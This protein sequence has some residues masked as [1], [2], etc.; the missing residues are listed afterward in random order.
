MSWWT[1]YEFLYIIHG[2]TI[3]VMIVRK[4][5]NH[6]EPVHI[7]ALSPLVDLIF[8]FSNYFIYEL[9]SLVWLGPVLYKTSMFFDNYLWY[10]FCLDVIVGDL[11]GFIFVRWALYYH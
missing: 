8:I 7:L 4:H 11:N 5:I 6:I 10:C 1:I 9:A 3:M 2:V